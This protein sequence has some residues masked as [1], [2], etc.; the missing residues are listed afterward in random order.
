MLIDHASPHPRTVQ[1][2]GPAISDLGLDRGGLWKAYQAVRGT[3]EA[4]CAPLEIEDY[5]IQSM[6][7]ASPAKWHLA[8]TTWFFETF[9]PRH[10]AHFEPVDPMYSYLFNSYYDAVGERIARD[11]R[12]LLSRP[13]VAEIYLYRALVD[14]AIEALLEAATEDKLRQIR[15]PLIL[16]LHHEQQHQELILTDIKHALGSNP[17]HP[18]YRKAKPGP[19]SATRIKPLGWIEFPEGLRTIGHDG[20]G[21]AFD[22]EAPRHQEYVAPFAIADRLVTN[23]EYFEFIQDLGYRRHSFWLSDGWTAA[24]GDKWYAPLY[25]EA[26]DDHRWWQ[27]TLAGRRELELDQPVCHV[28][29]FAADAYA[30]WAGYRLPTEAEWETAVIE[31]GA[32]RDGNFLESGRIHPAALSEQPRPA[33]SAPAQLFGD[34]WEWTQSAYSPYRGFRPA[35][36]AIGEYNGKFMCNQYVLRGGSCVTPGSH[37]RA[38]Y[39]NFFPADARWQFSGIRLARDV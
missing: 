14:Q 32:A 22:N 21:F 8:H 18:A 37:I 29:Y 10:D 5:V 27:F 19:P 3:T 4:L 28:S 12:G 25:G 11:R 23:R 33:G 17:L 16:G 20:T 15:G 36:G 35:K 34:V 24:R 7:E 39:R 13:T 1:D 2:P 30:R 38:T 26:T 31:S 9:V 6:T